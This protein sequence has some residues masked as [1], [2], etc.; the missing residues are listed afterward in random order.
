MSVFR[1]TISPDGKYLAAWGDNRV[2]SAL[3][4]WNIE[5][6]TQTAGLQSSARDVVDL[7]FS[8][9]SNVLAAC[10]S[11]GDIWLWDVDSGKQT[12]TLKINLARYQGNA[13]NSLEFS[14][15]GMH[16]T[17]TAVEFVSL[18]DLRTGTET[19]ELNHYA[20]SSSALPDSGSSWFSPDGHSVVLAAS[21]EIRVYDVETGQ[22]RLGLTSDYV[23]MVRFSPDSSRLA[24]IQKTGVQVWQI[25]SSKLLFKIDE[26]LDYPDVG[27]KEFSPDGAILL[28][29]KTDGVLQLWDG[30]TG[31]W[32]TEL[33]GHTQYVY[34]AV[35]SPDRTLLLTVGADG[36]ARLWAVQ[37]G[38]WITF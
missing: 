6:G 28:L 26:P 34:D 13:T 24:V 20:A 38:S 32:L 21:H 5:S 18:W 2:G 36:T 22:Q 3:V 15:D 31:K 4:I 1:F 8:P 30:Q 16:L 35:F 10:D 27:I 7:V 37:G 12:L 25:A 29:A 17:A 23:P 19:A 33:R 11:Q 9:D 14:P